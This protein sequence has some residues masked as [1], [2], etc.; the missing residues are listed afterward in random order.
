MPVHTEQKPKYVLLAERLRGE[1]ASGAMK[2]G[3]RLPPY[4]EAQ[5][6]YGTT[7]H[8]LDRAQALL[9]QDGLIVRRPGSGVYV[10]GPKRRTRTGLIGVVQTPAALHFGAGGPAPCSYESHLLHG[11]KAAAQQNGVVV[12]LLRT[13]VTAGWEK[14]DGI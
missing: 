10:A 1:I 6:R 9:E 12:L 5:Q 14:V 11:I 7:K 3:D 13:H 8:T 4:G 2:A